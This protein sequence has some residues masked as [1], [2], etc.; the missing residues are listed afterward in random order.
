ML[1]REEIERER[2]KMTPEQEAE[3]LKRISAMS[4]ARPQR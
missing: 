2:P 1:P 4:K 3:I